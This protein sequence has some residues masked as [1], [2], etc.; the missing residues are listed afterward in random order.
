MSYIEGSNVSIGHLGLVS[1]T[2]DLIELE[3][4][5]DLLLPKKRHH[6]VSHGTVIK[7]MIL[8]GLGFIDRR[9]YIMSEFFEDVATGRLLGH[10]IDP[11][12][13]NDDLFGRTLD[14]IAAYGPSR[15]FNEVA[16][17]MMETLSMGVQ[18]LHH[19]TTSFNVTGQYDRSFN[20][21]LIAL[22]HGHSKDHRDD[23]KQFVLS[24]STNQNAI[25]LFTRPYS[26]N[27]SDK[28]ILLETI[29]AVHASL[30]ST[31]KVYHIADSAI[32][33]NANI[34]ALG[35][36]CHWITRVPMTI[37]AAQELVSRD[38]TWSA[39]QDPRYKYVEIVTE[40]AG[41]PQ[42]WVLYHSEPAQKRAEKT[43][44]ARIEKDRKKDQTSLNKLQSTDF[45]CEA[46]AWAELNRWKDKHP[47]YILCD[48][49]VTSKMKKKSGKRGRPSKG[50]VLVPVFSVSCSLTWN[51]EYVAWERERKGRFILA[52]NDINLDPD[53]IL[54]WYK[55]QY[56]IERG[57][58]FLKDDSFHIADI[59]LKK[60]S[61]IAALAVVMVICLLVYGVTEWRLRTV[62]STCNKTVRNQVRKQTAR[63]TM[64]WVYFLFRR[65]RQFAV[66]VEDTVQIRITNYSDELR[67]IVHILGPQ[68]ENYYF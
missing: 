54:T 67:D 34:S 13:L 35:R 56:T 42:K 47:R 38:V 45:A 10:G 22:T 32:F 1:G 16:M 57:F 58:R 40:Y 36:H 44:A 55:E 59:M 48:A 25:P 49:S 4:I 28:K 52:T 7:A 68:Y 3:K 43:F 46:D 30:K 39:C 21:Q 6:K 53:T 5:T 8:N 14:A 27:E 65:V 66:S 37:T 12:C 62:L 61:R 29:Q 9:L 18:R 19:D 50:E 17:H 15:Y 2:C 20:T 23:L 33:T 26:G 51:D 60:P 41:I 31:E 11:S 64:K 63:P 24:I